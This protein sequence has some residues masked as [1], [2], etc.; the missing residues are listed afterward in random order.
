MKRYV[1]SIAENGDRIVT[2]DG[3]KLAPHLDV[4]N[5]SPTGFAWGYGGSGPS[6]LALAICIDALGGDVDRAF[7]VY[8]SFKWRIIAHLD[9]GREWEL[10][11][12]FILETIVA[13]EAEKAER[14]ET[15]PTTKAPF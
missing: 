10:T 13:L 3:A 6:Q 2:V 9:E 14:A 11:Q 15:P 8:Q 7:N 4:M 12:S 1:G 5:H